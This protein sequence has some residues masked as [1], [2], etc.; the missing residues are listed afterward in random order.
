MLRCALTG[1]VPK[2]PVVSPQGVV[3][4][5]DVIA[6]HLGT[7]NFCPVKN[8][9]LRFEDLIDIE[10]AQPT[11]YPAAIHAV[12]F[13]DHLKGL[14]DEWNIMQKE[15]YETRKKLA[16]CQRELAQALYENEAAKRVIAKMVAEGS[17]TIIRPGE[18]DLRN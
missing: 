17:A 5:R 3:F 8:V 6:E 12:S 16:Q 11:V 1:V 15:L 9:P 4:E 13:S 18:D 14:T 10:I 7:S 2:N